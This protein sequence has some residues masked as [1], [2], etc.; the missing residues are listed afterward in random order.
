MCRWL[1]CENLRGFLTSRPPL[2]M[3][4]LLLGVF[5]VTLWVLANIVEVKN[6]KN[7]DETDWNDFLSG[8]RKVQ[9]CMLLDEV[10]AGNETEHIAHQ[11]YKDI[12]AKVHGKFEFAADRASTPSTVEIVEVSIPMWV[13]LN[14]TA[15]L[16]NIP[17]NVSLLSTTMSGRQLGITGENAGTEFNVTL[18]LPVKWNSSMCVHNN[19]CSVLKIQTCLLLKA[20]SSLFPNSR[21][22]SCS[23]LGISNSTDEVPSHFRMVS[24]DRSKV[25]PKDLVC[26]SSPSITLDHRDDLDLTIW[27]TMHDKSV[28]DLHLMHTSFFLF[29]MVVTLLAYAVVK[30]KAHATYKTKTYS[31]VPNEA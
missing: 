22:P 11:S 9:F 6:L 5:A 21:T 18:S 28:I 30:G 23:Q 1:I 19:P 27:L 25:R 26:D 10:E 3:F 17:H 15:E 20:P 14:P 13:E 16:V 4:M 12:M 2:V 31:E 24:K 29:I 8:F 7:P